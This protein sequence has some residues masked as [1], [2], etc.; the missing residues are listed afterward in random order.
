MKRQHLKTKTLGT[1]ISNI[2]EEIITTLNIDDDTIALYFGYTLL[3][4]Q[5]ITG[6]VLV[7]TILCQE[8][9]IMEEVNF[10]LCF[11]NF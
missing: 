8:N 5:S 10:A 3:V 11:N 2:A 6:N 4:K 7:L 1:A 9:K